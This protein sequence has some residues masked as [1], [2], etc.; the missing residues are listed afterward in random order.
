[1]GGDFIGE[2]LRKKVVDDGTVKI[3]LTNIKPT[4]YG[5]LGEA[6]DPVPQIGTTTPVFVTDEW[7]SPQQNELDELSIIPGTYGA[8]ALGMAYIL[9]KEDESLRSKT[10]FS[11]LNFNNMPS[12]DYLMQKIFNLLSCD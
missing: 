7:D 9:I 11:D 8:L 10:E 6:G 1:M 12:L 2:V 4:A 3:L 5:D